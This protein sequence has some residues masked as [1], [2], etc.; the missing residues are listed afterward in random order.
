MSACRRSTLAEFNSPT[1]DLYEQSRP[2]EKISDYNI[3][4]G[5]SQSVVMCC[6]KRT[7]E[8]TWEAFSLG[9]QSAGCCYSYSPIVRSII[10]LFADHNAG[11]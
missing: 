3:S 4:N 5:D 7:E 11:L 1:V 2:R 9:T 8:G 6:M 10:R